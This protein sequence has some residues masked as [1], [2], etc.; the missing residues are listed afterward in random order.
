MTTSARTRRRLLW[1]GAICA[2]AVAGLLVFLLVPNKKGGIAT[3]AQTAPVQRVPHLRQVPVTPERHAAIDR[4]F[5][6]FVPLAMAA[7]YSATK[8]ALHSYSL[9][10][11]YKLRNTSLRVLEVAPPWVQTDLLNSNDEPRAMPLAEFIEETMRVLGTGADEV[12]VERA[13]PL[14]NNVGPGEAAL[15]KEFNDQMVRTQ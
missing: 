6:Q 2:A 12:L 11:R 10:L 1:L 8:A 4:L 15:V 3:P 7:V 5:N 13:K 9:S 14:R